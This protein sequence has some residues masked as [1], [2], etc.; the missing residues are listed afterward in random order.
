MGLSGKIINCSPCCCCF[1][2]YWPNGLQVSFTATSSRPC[3]DGGAFYYSSSGSASGTIDLFRSDDDCQAEPV[4]ESFTDA[5]VD[6]KYSDDSCASEVTDAT[7]PKFFDMHVTAFYSK[8]IKR[9]E[10]NYN[11]NF[12]RLRFYCDGTFIPAESYNYDG[13]GI[14]NLTVSL[15]DL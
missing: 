12:A 10:V 13:S 11:T 15:L 3:F 5:L 6:R 14:N 8:T 7:Y 2:Q 4:I 9:I 1:D